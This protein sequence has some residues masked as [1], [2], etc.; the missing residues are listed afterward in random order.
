MLDGTP[1]RAV[2]DSRLGLIMHFVEYIHTSLGVVSVGWHTC[3]QYKMTA[4]WKFVTWKGSEELCMIANSDVRW[5]ILLNAPYQSS[6]VN[7]IYLYNAILELKWYVVFSTVH[8]VSFQ[9]RIK[10]IWLTL[11][12]HKNG[13]KIM[14]CVYSFYV[15]WDALQ[16]LW[17]IAIWDWRLILV[18]ALAV[19]SVAGIYLDSTEW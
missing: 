9:C 7:G 5:C 16:Q 17:M 19:I 13:L 3:W 14:H 15:G 4:N 1:W 2:T 12:N 11:N 10:G 18:Y 6:L 8:L